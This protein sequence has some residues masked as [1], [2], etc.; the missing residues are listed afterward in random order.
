MN[1]SFNINRFWLLVGRQWSENKKSY[2]FLW[3]VISLSLMIFS[4]FSEQIGLELFILLFCFGGCVVITTVFSSWPDFGRSSL[5]LLL[6]ASLTEKF[7]CGLFY[8]I[9]LF[10]PV[11]CLTYFFITYI[12]TY[13]V[14][15]LFPNNLISFSE[16]ITD[17]INKFTFLP[18]SFYIAV[19][20]A[21]LFMQS[22]YMIIIIRF[23]KRQILIFLLT[24]LAILVLYNFG[25][26]ILMSNIVHA[27]KGHIRTPGPLLTFITADFGY[28]K[29]IYNP[30]DFES[31]S[32]IKLIWKLNDLIWF[33]VF[34]MLYLTAWFKFKEREL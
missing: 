32:F 12:F 15:L 1:N 8:G 11:Y 25:M 2:L 5:Y 21:F 29:S 3:I 4:V 16:V 18:F 28:I 30:A 10:I 14:I 9:I 34:C 7:L 27:P 17:G 22:L 26:N 31:F 24:I 19:F 20:L 13:L 23:K 33:I 6:P